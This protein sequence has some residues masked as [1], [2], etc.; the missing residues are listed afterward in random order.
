VLKA[1]GKGLRAPFSEGA[2]LFEKGS[3]SPIVC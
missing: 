3:S 2:I 1:D